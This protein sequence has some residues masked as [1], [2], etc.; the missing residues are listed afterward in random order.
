MLNSL[1]YCELCNK[2]YSNEHCLK[3]HNLQHLTKKPFGCLYCEKS[4]TQKA[5]LAEHINRHN[6]TPPYI[7][8]LCKKG[9]Y[10]KDR[11][12]THEL[13]HTG[14]RPFKCEVCSYECR[15]QYELNRHIKIHDKLAR[16]KLMKFICECGKRNYSQA[17]LD[18]HRMTHST[19]RKFKC[20]VC[21]KDL[22]TK[23]TLRD[24]LAAVHFPFYG[25]RIVGN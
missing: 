10:Q 18:R 6:G 9:F 24:H 23:Y 4:F 16:E 1:T 15:R 3:Q 17:E 12:K 8:A 21:S 5:K 19:E 2:E 25:E 7:C 20:H 11:L 22:K 14:E 13:N